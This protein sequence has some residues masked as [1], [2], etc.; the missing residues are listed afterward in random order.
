MT[1]LKSSFI[2]RDAATLDL[3]PSV[4]IENLIRQRTAVLER[5]EEA[6]R[7]IREAN[8]IAHAG[9]LGQLDVRL[10]YSSAAECPF[11]AQDVMQH[12][13]HEVDAAAWD[14]LMSESGLR[15]IMDAEARQTWDRQITRGEIPALTLENILATFE[16]LHNTRD[17]M[18][19]RGVI[20]CF[21]RLS[22]DYKTNQPFKFGKRIIVDYLFQTYGKGKDRWLSLNLSVTNELDDLVRVLSVLDGKLEPD[23]RQGMEG[24]L[25][26]AQNARRMDW[27]GDYFFLRWYRKGT[28]HLAFRRLDLV[29]QM[30]AILA[31]HFPGALPAPRD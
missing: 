29:E 16:V 7:L 19:D 18:F 2:E 25:R 4:S 31:K 5:V 1:E 10:R 14:Y 12:A 28:G 23:H 8:D 15:T 30:N 9:H 20:E 13:R 21:K 26:R 17:A 6:I 24:Q 22:W 11:A 27:E 3:I